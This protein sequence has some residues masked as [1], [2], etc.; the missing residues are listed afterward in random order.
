MKTNPAFQMGSPDI[1]DTSTKL[2]LL[3]LSQIRGVGYFSIRRLY[4]SHKDVNAIWR[5]D[6]EDLR[7][8]L[9]GIPFLEKVISKIHN[10][11]EELLERATKLMSELN[12]ASVKLI[13]ESDHLFPRSLMQIK[14]PPH[15]LFVE[16]DVS[17][18]SSQRCVAV[19]GSRR[20]DESSVRLAKKLT[21]LLIASQ[22]TVVS[23]LAEGID[24]AAHE[25]AIALGGKT[26]AVLGHGI[27]Q[28][29]PASTVS[30]RNRI[31]ERSGATITEYFP[32]E[33]YSRN[34]FLWR[35]RLQSGLSI[36]VVPI[37]S[38]LNGGTARTVRYAVEQHK[39]VFGVRFHDLRPSPKNEVYELLRSIGKPVFTVPAE[40]KDIQKFLGSVQHT[41]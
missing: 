22:Y 6:K 41:S 33:R 29:F 38:T 14:E 4:E 7:G 30:L 31:K 24:A 11:K 23:G 16:G 10:S 2:T 25:T 37:E 3:A 40:S 39:D 34:Y 1:P 28:S 8:V 19:V 15:W 13:L 17:A 35:N 9:D 21:E 20:P 12:G 32:K 5:A 36:A 18:L 27:A 26:I